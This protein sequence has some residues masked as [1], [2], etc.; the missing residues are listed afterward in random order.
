M[1]YSDS[2]GPGALDVVD[3]ESIAALDAVAVG[4]LDHLRRDTTK[5]HA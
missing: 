3:M 1:F 5:R 4:V 2:C